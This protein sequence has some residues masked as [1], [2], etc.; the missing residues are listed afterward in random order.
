MILLLLS[1]LY[2]RFVHL[3]NFDVAGMNLQRKNTSM[4]LRPI[5]VQANQRQ[6]ILR[7]R[8]V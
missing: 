8:G 6:Q 4:Q 5:P 3:L 7:R 2:K 1:Y